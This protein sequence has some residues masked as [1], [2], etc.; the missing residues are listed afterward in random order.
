MGA[1]SGSSKAL[2]EKNSDNGNIKQKDSVD[3]T[4]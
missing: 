1:R 2:L 3:S 4:Y